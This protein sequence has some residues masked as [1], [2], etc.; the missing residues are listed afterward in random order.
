MRRVWTRDDA[1]TLRRDD[2][3][4]SLTGYVAISST[5]L[6]ETVTV[7]KAS[8]TNR[9]D[10]HSFLKSV[11]LATKS[12][13]SVK[14]FLVLDG[15]S[16][17]FTPENRVLLNQY[18]VPL[19][20]PA[21]S[22]QFNSVETLFAVAKTNLRRLIAL[23]D[24]QMTQDRFESLVKLSIGMVDNAAMQGIIRSNRRDLSSYLTN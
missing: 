5:A 1:V 21:H 8:T 14:P 13:M 10:F 12:S 6:N 24:D 19:R 20:M 9:H 17:H 2:K 11:I 7:M 15:H 16:A 22:C 4:F 18:F 3:R 23:E